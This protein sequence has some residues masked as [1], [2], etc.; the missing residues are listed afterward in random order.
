MDIDKEKKV[1]ASEETTPDVDDAAIK[2]NLD[3]ADDNQGDKSIEEEESQGKMFIMEDDFDKQLTQAEG[4]PRKQM[5]VEGMHLKV[6]MGDKE[7]PGG[8]VEGFANAFNNVD[9]QGEVV[10]PGAFKRTIQ[11]FKKSKKGLPFMDNHR[12]FGGT[13]SVIGRV[14]EL[15]EE[16]KGLF[17]KAFFSSSP[18]AQVVRTKIHEKVLDSL[19]IGF[20]IVKRK[21][22]KDG[23]VEL[24]ELKLREVSVVV[25]PANELAT[26]S[27]VKAAISRIGICEDLS[28]EFDEALAAKRWAEYCG[29]GRSMVSWGDF[30]WTKY[31]G[32]FALVDMDAA[33]REKSFRCPVVDVID[34]EPCI[35]YAGVKA[36]LEIVGESDKFLKGLLEKFP[37]PKEKSEPEAEEGAEQAEVQS[38]INDNVTVSKKT[39]EALRQLEVELI[40]AKRTRMMRELRVEFDAA[41]E[42][43]L[44]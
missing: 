15:R 20:N 8:T 29:T 19:S 39:E 42:H 40:R 35:V 31:I 16:K 4:H 11:A 34:G 1:T 3:A 17:F 24:L 14:F 25:F 33:T 22:R 44:G 18:A 5:V 37:T 27:D 13:D 32:G 2:R 12:I 21:V 36:A 43:F 6:I 30:E 23:V 41:R 7:F 28:R 9:F 10:K 26:V 38:T